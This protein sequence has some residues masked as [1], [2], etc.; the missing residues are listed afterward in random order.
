MGVDDDNDLGG[1]VVGQ[2]LGEV[3][4]PE[5]VVGCGVFPLCLVCRPIKRDL[6]MAD[7]FWGHYCW[8]VLRVEIDTYKVLVANVLHQHLLME[9]PTKCSPPRVHVKVER[10]DHN[11]RVVSEGY[12]SLAI[13]TAVIEIFNL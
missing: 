4:H 7:L 3:A 6:D 1:R 11:R 10:D 13:P 9:A 8:H 12:P 2:K 5:D